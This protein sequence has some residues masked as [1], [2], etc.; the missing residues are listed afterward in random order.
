[1]DESVDILETKIRKVEK[2]DLRAVSEIAIKGWQTAYRGVIDDEFLNNMSI[3]EN[4]QKRLKDY[5][6]N[7]FVVATLKKE[8]VGFCRYRTGNYYKNE[9]DSVDCEICALYVKPDCKRNG[10]GTKLVNYVINE[11][12]EN[13]N[14]QMILWCLKDNYPSRNFYEKL[15]GIYCGE[16]VIERGNKEY[17]EVGYIYDLKKLPKDELE[18]V[19]PT[20]EYKKEVEE[21]LQEFLDNGEKEIAGDGGLDRIKDFDK[22]L[23]KV[24][25]DLSNET[26]DKDRIPATVYLTIR[27]SDKKIVGN[28]QIRHFLNKKLLNYGG[29]IGDSVRPSE[30]RKGYATEQIRLA[31]EKCRDLGIDNVLMDCD[32][33][34]I[35]S[36][37]SIKNNGGVLENEIYVGDEIVQRY[38]ISL[39]K[40]FVTNPNNMKIVKDGNL[41]I[42]T[43]NNSD[44]IGDIAL[45]KFNKM[46]KS[47]MVE[48][49]NLCIAGDN[50]KWLEFY[51]Y[52][53]KYR[54]TAMYNEKNEIVEWY[55]DIARR[56][57]KEKG[58]PYE[59]DLYLDVVVTP[60]EDIILLDEDELKKA[61]NRFEVNQ[62]DYNMAYKEAKQLMNTLKDNKN[63]L[64]E[65][66]E[67]YLKEMLKE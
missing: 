34:N 5:K 59:D 62:F 53:K 33:T 54:L 3:E 38:W 1:M 37:K 24:Q 56:I 20:K 51:D 46:Y 41:K 45:I 26:I 48:N 67:K 63:K 12:K 18:L 64:K 10:I 55:F 2:E 8:I 9:Y 21:Y 13:G 30:R 19:I 32:K 28:L 50:Y 29:H 31:L 43:F 49:T 35:G 52:N 15:G 57:G 22:W 58:M 61:F 40:R 25:N 47:Y 11:F 16:N 60:K 14:V 7:R 36:A 65:F 44:F 27:K 6:E 66:T 39:K 4:Y 23:G 17:K 42:K